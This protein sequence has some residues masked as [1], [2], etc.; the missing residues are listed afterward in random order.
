MS[1]FTD[2]AVDA[3]CLSEYFGCLPYGLLFSG[4]VDWASSQHGGLWIPTG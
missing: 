3:S 4:R 2:L 1:S